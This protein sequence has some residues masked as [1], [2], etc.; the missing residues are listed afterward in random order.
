MNTKLLRVWVI[1][2]A[3]FVLLLATTTGFA[4][5]QKQDGTTA[6]EVRKN[7]AQT[8]E[9]LKDYTVQQRDKAVTDA[10][11]ELD[12]LD[13][14]IDEMQRD[15]D[16]HWQDMSVITRKKTRESLDLLRRKREE[17]AEWYGGLK[18]SSAD[19]WEEVKK[20]FSDSYDRLEQ[21]VKK[22]AK[23]FDKED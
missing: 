21:A 20:G 10:K 19:A 4:A 15:I 8:Y 7:A 16:E 14:R 1:L 13:R 11:E 5:E 23:E 17:V 6:A 22:A 9:S 3:T 12:N 2:S 18:H